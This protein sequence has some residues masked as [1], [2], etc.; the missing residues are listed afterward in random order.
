MNAYILSTMDTCCSKIEYL[1]NTGFRQ[2]E[3]CIGWNLHRKD[4]HFDVDCAEFLVV[5]FLG[6]PTVGVAIE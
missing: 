1:G 6:S 4:V 2:I 3:P 5:A